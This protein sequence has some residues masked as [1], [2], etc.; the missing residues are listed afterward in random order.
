MTVCKQWCI[1]IAIGL[2]GLVFGGF[3]PAF[4]KMP[5][6]AFQGCKKQR[7]APG[8]P[9]LASSPIKSPREVIKDRVFASAPIMQ[10][11]AGPPD[12]LA[13][14]CWF[15]V[16]GVWTDDRKLSLDMSV[17]TA[18]WASDSRELLSLANGTYVR[19]SMLVIAPSKNSNKELTVID[20]LAPDRATTFESADSQTLDKVLRRGGAK[21]TYRATPP[22]FHGQS[23]VIDVTRSGLARIKVNNKAYYRPHPA[24]SAAEVRLNVDPNDAFYMN[25]ALENLS[26]IRQGYDISTQ[27]PFY[28]LSNDK[29]NIFTDAGAYYIEER[30]VLPIG[31]RLVQEAS[32]GM[33]YRKDII[34]H[35]T[36]LQQSFAL[37]FGGKSGADIP[38]VVKATVAADTVRENT[39]ALQENNTS[40]QA[41][42]Y[43]RN[44]QYALVLNY[45]YSTLSDRFVDMLSDAA[46]ALKKNPGR[47]NAYLKSILSTFGTHYPYAV[48]YGATAKMTQSFSEESYIEEFG[49]SNST[50]VEVVAELYGLGGSLHGGVMSGRKTGTSGSIGSEGA[51]FVA[52]GGN[53][54]WDQNGYSAGGTPYP[55]LLDLRPIYE[56][57][58]PINF[59]GETQI[60]EDTRFALKQEFARYLRGRRKN[61]PN[62]YFKPDVKIVGKYVA[63]YETPSDWQFSMNGRDTLMVK[64]GF[65]KNAKPL[66]FKRNTPNNFFRALTTG[67]FVQYATSKSGYV[68]MQDDRVDYQVRLYPVNRP[69][70]PNQRSVTGTYFVRDQPQ[71]SAQFKMVNQSL[72]S[73]ASSWAKGKTPT[74]FARRSENSFGNEA[75]VVTLLDDGTVSAYSIKKKTTTIYV[76]SKKP[77][78]PG[79]KAIDGTYVGVANSNNSVRWTMVN[80]NLAT[81]V[82]SW[83]NDGKNTERWLRSAPDTFGLYG[84]RNAWRVNPDGSITLHSAK[85]GKKFTFVKQARQVK[86]KPKKS[87]PPAVFFAAP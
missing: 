17:D 51:T 44:K 24:Q 11:Q 16:D 35:G 37:S 77:L 72:L 1:L 76:P 19:P 87:N 66:A 13:G 79:S 14:A 69:M 82:P 22:S 80:Q 40:A 29:E 73:F 55:I 68:I 25:N 64:S 31:V 6:D 26:A 54:S 75:D 5:V 4:A 43:S 10:A 15:R 62:E 70:F 58:N 32:Q 30:R 45:A 60:Y 59:P 33:V 83:I 52:V 27:D 21:K 61:I 50:S 86:A 48:T 41:I 7:T 53:G 2:F 49:S 84:Q 74:V 23:L 56:L 12:D 18:G 20:A 34:T 67:G 78:F 38:Y 36:Q 9:S 8:D 46:A 71:H 42:G 65:G 63:D 3:G 57:L 81:A 47:S 28:L 85:S 39:Y